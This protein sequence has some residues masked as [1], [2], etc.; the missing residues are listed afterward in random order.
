[1]KVLRENIR[2]LYN[3]L[4]NKDFFE[5]P[6][7][8]QFRFMVIANVNLLETELTK[9]MEFDN[10]FVY[11]ENHTEYDAKRKAILAEY[12]V[13]SISDFEGLAPNIAISF[14]SEIKSLNEEYKDVVS[15]INDLKESK[16]TYYGEAVEI[17]LKTIKS[18]LVPVISSAVGDN[19]WAIWNTLMPLIVD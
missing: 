10:Q 16:Q 2:N 6:I 4:N 18:E 7:S 9:M 3:V 17:P 1:M 11:P 8:S 12:G 13:S 15:F 5:M 14:E 19:H